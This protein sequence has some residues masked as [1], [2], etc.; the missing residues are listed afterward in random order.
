MEKRQH[1]T[2]LEA[3]REYLLRGLYGFIEDT[4]IEYIREQITLIVRQ[5][6]GICIEDRHLDKQIE[7]VVPPTAHHGKHGGGTYAL[8]EDRLILR[9]DTYR[10]VDNYPH[11]N[12]EYDRW[13]DLHIGYVSIS[14]DLTTGEVTQTE[15]VRK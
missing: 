9:L 13:D 11:C 8:R 3:G 5:N 6:G 2:A 7:L 14:Y 12:G 10:V 4:Q 15:E 1:D